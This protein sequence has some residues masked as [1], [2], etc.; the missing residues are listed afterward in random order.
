MPGRKTVSQ[1]SAP[2]TTTP[3]GSSEES[4][5]KR[6]AACIAALAVALLAAGAPM[7]SAATSAASTKPKFKVYRV[8]TTVAVIPLA[9][10]GRE[11]SMTIEGTLSSAKPA[12]T[13]NMEVSG[14]YT[15]GGQQR[16]YGPAKSD[17][18]G[19]WSAT[20]S[21]VSPTSERDV[22]VRI[23][24]RRA[25]ARVICGTGFHF[26]ELHFPMTF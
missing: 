7:A 24:A 9:T 1:A 23:T 4:W 3:T 18:A 11:V 17:P 15:N 21:H 16:N 12:C 13:R 2:Q 22:V 25:S 8:K 10:E 5:L 26:E 20:L 14:Y 6:S 19:H